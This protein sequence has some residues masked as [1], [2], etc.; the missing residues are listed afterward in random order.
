ME[1]ISCRFLIFQYLLLWLSPPPSTIRRMPSTSKILSEDKEEEEEEEIGGDDGDDEP[2]G[3]KGSRR[4]KDAKDRTSN[5]ENGEHEMNVQRKSKRKNLKIPVQCVNL[6]SEYLQWED[7]STKTALPIIFNNPSLLS[8]YSLNSDITDLE[9]FSFNT[10]KN[11]VYNYEER[12]EKEKE[13]ARKEGHRKLKSMV[14][15]ISNHNLE[16]SKERNKNV[17]TC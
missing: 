7:L 17:T 16:T 9:F 10:D 14:L 12:N 3:Q 13:D 8:S 6:I 2:D 11:K 5:S 15:K 4:K 1:N